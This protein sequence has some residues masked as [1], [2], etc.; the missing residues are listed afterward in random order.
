MAKSDDF[1]P[2][3][4]STVAILILLRPFAA[5]LNL[6]TPLPVAQGLSA[7]VLLL[8]SG[9]LAILLRRSPWGFGKLILYS[10]GLG[11]VGCML[12]WLIPLK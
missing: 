4:L 7:A 12:A 2:Q 9:S 8:A 11:V 6:W 10:A 3:F 1:A 5:L